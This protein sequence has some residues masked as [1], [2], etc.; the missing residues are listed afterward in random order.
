MTHGGRIRIGAMVGIGLLVLGS[1]CGLQHREVRE[2]P[3]GGYQTSH[4]TVTY[5]TETACVGTCAGR[6]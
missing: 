3:V 2:R 5:D 4:H 1:G 6:E